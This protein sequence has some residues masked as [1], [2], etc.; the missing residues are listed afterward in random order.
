MRPS[1]SHGAGRLQRVLGVG[2]G[3]AITIGNTVGAGI[4]RTPGTIAA[5]LPTLGLITAIWLVGG[6]YS[7][8]AANALTELGTM[9]P[10]EG[11]QYV[12]VRHALG[13]YAG[14]I[15]GWTDWAAQCGSTAALTIVVAESL[16]ALAP[17][18]G[19]HLVA[20]ALAIVV[21][22]T[23]LL[24]RGVQWS[25]W[26]QGLTSVL[27]GVALV[28]LVVACLAAAM[29]WL[30]GGGVLPIAPTGARLGLALV[31]SF[32]AVLFTYNGWAGVLYF[33]EEMRDAARNVPRA[34]FSGLGAVIVLYVV[35]NLAYVAVLPMSALASAAVPA[36]AAARAIAGARG[37]AVVH[38][39][40]AITLVSSI[41]ANLLI[42]SR[43]A[44]ALARDGL[45][46]HAGARVNA[47]G[48]PEIALAV[49]AAVAIAFLLSG[50]FE[51]V[52]A[53]LAIFYVLEYTLS[54]TALFILRRR[55]PTAA[56]P[57]R[58]LGHPWTTGIVLAGSAGF[59]LAAVVGDPRHTAAA[60]AVVALSY[61]VYRW[62]GPKAPATMTGAVP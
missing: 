31:I 4:L 9:L 23:I 15:V 45:L 33:G 17:R 48:T 24:W 29:H 16:A 37:N 42:A 14:F 20:M 30:R 57:W 49:S 62:R 7:L 22:L 51:T 13:P 12:Y 2:F 47:G 18:L 40:I 21:A 8:L 5:R 41:T 34:L 19:L 6:A 46:P 61:P 50:A 39:L 26:V 28:V 36:A 32:Q 54:L 58:A 3:V 53:V 55:E 25:D 43:I 52:I 59:L 60:A 38:V 44:F 10:M 1:H 11:G 27:K 35:V 56:R